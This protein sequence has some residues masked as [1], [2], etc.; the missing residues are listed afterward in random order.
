MLIVGAKN[1]KSENDSQSS[2]SHHAQPF[3]NWLVSSF[4]FIINQIRI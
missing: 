1:A 3:V 2:F 4:Q